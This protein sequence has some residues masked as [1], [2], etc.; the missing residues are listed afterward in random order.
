LVLAACSKGLG[1]VINGQGIMQSEVV[2][3]EANIPEDQII[4]T[5]VAMGYPNDDFVANQVRSRRTPNEQVATFIGF[6]E[7]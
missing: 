7:D 1:S 2:R 4:I 5:C 3:K 6:D